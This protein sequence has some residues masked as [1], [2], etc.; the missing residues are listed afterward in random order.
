TDPVG[1]VTTPDVTATGSVFS[2]VVP[3]AQPGQYQLR[4]MNEAANPA[5]FTDVLNVWPEVPRFL[6]SMDEARLAVGSLPPLAGRDQLLRLFNAS[7]TIVLE[8]VVG[9]IL[10]LPKTQTTN[11]GRPAIVLWHKITPD[12]TVTV[13][14]DGTAWQDDAFVIDAAA[15]IVYAKSGWF[16]KGIQ[17]VVIEYSSGAPVIPANLQQAATELIRHQ[18]QVGYQAVHAEWSTDPSGDDQ[19]A[20][21]PSG[22]LIPRRVMQLCRPTPK[23]PGF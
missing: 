10:P 12:T 6:L 5:T 7:G 16:P 21:T 20:E 4:W 23:L 13:T 14:V 18:Y 17:N 15:A 8:D 19:L 2:S 3:T 9:T 1:A 11:G 22:F